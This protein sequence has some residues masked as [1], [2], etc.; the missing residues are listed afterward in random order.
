MIARTKER[1]FIKEGLFYFRNNQKIPIVHNVGGANQFRAI[2]NFGY[3]KGN[4][5][6]KKITYVVVK[7][8][9]KAFN[10]IE[11]ILLKIKK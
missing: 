2:S 10:Y 5:H 7:E 9:F 1:F 3:G 11:R 6:F 8:L 4:N